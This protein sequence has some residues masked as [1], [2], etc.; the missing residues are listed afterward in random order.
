MGD[1]RANVTV[2]L[3]E[4]QTALSAVDESSIAAFTEMLLG[5]DKV[6]VVG[7]GRVMLSLQAFVKRLNHIGI[8]A[9]YVG[10]VNE[11]AITE[12]DLLIVAS[13]SGESAVP[14]AIAKIAKE[15]GA[16]IVHIGSNPRSSLKPLTDLFIR[17]PVKTKLG[18]PDEVPSRQIMT[19][20]FDQSL[21]ILGDAVALGI[22]QRKKIN[23]KELW[24]FHAN[25]E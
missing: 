13:G 18:L 1:F 5:A 12:R 6:F 15:K 19:T 17:I 9:W 11:P 25:L 23:V 2:I 20:L 22:V 4:L 10:E 14:V 3:N 8:K 16:R 24:Q 7:V 21:L